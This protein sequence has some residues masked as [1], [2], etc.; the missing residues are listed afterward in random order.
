MSY[1]HIPTLRY[2]LRSKDI[3]AEHPNTSFPEIFV[4]PADYVEVVRTRQPD[5]DA[6]T[7]KVVEDA[8]ALIDG[9][10]TQRWLVVARSA[11][12]VQRA[13]E[14]AAMGVRA[15]RDAKLAATDWVVIK[16]MERGEAVSA[17]WAAYRQALRD[18]T[19]QAGFPV[20]VAW[21]VEPV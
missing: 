20:N 13:D 6:R 2:P 7:H 10:W 18:I 4:P 15:E 16:A 9:I 8:P 3:R 5:H 12:E 14:Q 19:A 11:E 1:I 17:A 21:P